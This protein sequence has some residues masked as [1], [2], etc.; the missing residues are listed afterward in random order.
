MLVREPRNC[1]VFRDPHVCLWPFVLREGEDA[2]G[3]G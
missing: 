2:F 1:V 3:C